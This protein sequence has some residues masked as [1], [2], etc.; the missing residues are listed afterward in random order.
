M[1]KV[2]IGEEQEKK[3]VLVQIGGKS[4]DTILAGAF[5]INLT[6]LVSDFYISGGHPMQQVRKS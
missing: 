6:F 1:E 4:R 2:W 3:V 5:Y